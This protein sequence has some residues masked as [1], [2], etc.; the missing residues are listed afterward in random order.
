MNCARTASWVHVSHCIINGNRCF[1]KISRDDFYFTIAGCDISN[2]KDARKSR[3][4]L[5]VC[6]DG[7]TNH[8]E[9]PVFHSSNRRRE[10]IVHD[11]V[12]NRKF[13]LI[14]TFSVFQ[15]NGLN[16]FAISNNFDLE[17][18]VLKFQRLILPIILRYILV[19]G[20]EDYG[21]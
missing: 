4:H 9:S 20:T 6:H 12:V 15:Y 11:K 1:T 5:A 14:F 13:D 19:R 17:D 7:V 10:A 2:G 8:I 16:V 3:F 21:E 18:T